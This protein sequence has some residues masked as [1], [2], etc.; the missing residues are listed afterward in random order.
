MHIPSLAASKLKPLMDAQVRHE[1][2]KKGPHDVRSFI[3]ACSFY[4]CHVK[5]F[6]FTSAILTDVVKKTTTWPLG[7]QEQQAFAE[8][9]DKVA[10]HR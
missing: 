10:T 9:K 7:P 5:N 8:P 1:D 3:G 6:T 4:R 2:L